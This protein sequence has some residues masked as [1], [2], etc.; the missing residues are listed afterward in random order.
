MNNLD[1]TNANNNETNNALTSKPAKTKK[2]SSGFIVGITLGLA[3]MLLLGYWSGIGS[4]LGLGSSKSNFVNKKTSDKLDQIDALL[5][6]KYLRDYDKSKLDD[7]IIKGYVA[8]LGDE[9]TAYFDAEE[10]EEFLN[11]ITGDFSGIGVVFSMD[12]TTQLPKA[13]EVYDD[14]PAS[15]SGVKVGDVL[16]KVNDE[17]ISGMD[18]DSVVALLRGKKGTKVKITVSRNNKNIDINITRDKIIVRTVSNEMMKDGIGYISV[19]QFTETTDAQFKEALD[20]LKQK[21]MKSLIVD[22]RGNPGG[23]VDACV[24]MLDEILPKGMAVYLKDKKGNKV[25]YKTTNETS[26][27]IPIVVLVD[28]DSASASEIFAGAIKDRK[29]GKII[30]ETTYGKGVVQEIFEL[31]GKTCIKI[32]TSEYFTPNGICIDGKGIDPDIKATDDNPLD[33]VDTVVNEAINYLK[34]I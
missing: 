10:T 1:N 7:S 2:F 9:Y 17:D 5:K 3:I 29:A 26:L 13:L 34:S 22:L 11:S 15:K 18:L 12:E 21:N 32:T 4:S 30:G 20:K 25:D 27:D 31:S 24:N 28:H 23:L 16:L 8:G 14:S 33:N 6:E 19:S